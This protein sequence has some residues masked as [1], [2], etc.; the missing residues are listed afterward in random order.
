MQ[1]RWEHAEADVQRLQEDLRLE[2]C[3]SY[4]LLCLFLDEAT[5]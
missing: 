4:K 2:R 3:R 1:M 5:K